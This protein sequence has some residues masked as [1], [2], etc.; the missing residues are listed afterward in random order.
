MG[1]ELLKRYD[2][3]F[4]NSS[5]EKLLDAEKKYS[6]N[7]FIR[8]NLSKSKSEKIE[9]FL[10]KNKVKF[11]KTFLPNSLKI[12][13]SFF[14]LSSS[15]ENISGEC[16]L[17]DLASQIPINLIDFK[18]LALKH[19]NSK[20]LCPTPYALCSVLDM[21]SSPGSKTTQIA[22][23]LEFN[24]IPYNII[25]LEPEKK[26]LT[27]LINNIQKQNF[28]NIKIINSTGENFISKEKFDIILLDAPCS[29]N[30]IDNK[31]W[32]NKRE[33]KGILEKSALQKKLLENASKLLKEN[34]ILIY[35]T[36]SLEPEENELNILFAEK[37]LKLKSIKTEII[38]FPFETNPTKIIKDKNL[39]E[40]IQNQNSIRIMPYLSQTQ[41]FF[42]CLLKKV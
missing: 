18:E 24:K 14:N 5:K 40:K 33:L 32:L 4:D 19:S 28:K 21:A 22:D 41:G 31:N 1:I 15:P 16:Y 39:L 2:L 10:K 8:I 29:G 11:S 3:F 17:Q 26:R 12:E 35:S 13:K 6:S 23:L 20:A 37:N 30:L 9:E 42:V 27:K 25:A 36:C 38:S 7:Q 34:G